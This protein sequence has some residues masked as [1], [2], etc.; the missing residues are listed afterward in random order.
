MHVASGWW[1]NL[2]NPAY[3]KANGDG[4]SEDEDGLTYRMEN[5][6]EET[7]KQLDSDN[8][9]EDEPDLKVQQVLMINCWH[10]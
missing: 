3:E 10:I 8:D 2:I 5:G 6:W 4:T 1:P 9:A 7:A